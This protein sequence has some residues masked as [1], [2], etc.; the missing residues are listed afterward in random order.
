MGRRRKWAL[1]SIAAAVVL[2]AGVGAAIAATRDTSPKQESQAALNDAAKELG[3]APAKLQTAIENALAKRVDAAVADGRLTTEQGEELKAR[4][5]AGDVPLLAPKLRRGHGHGHFKHFGKLEA[6][7]AYL[8]VGRAE[9]RTALASGK[10]LAE[11]ARDEGKS[12]D[13]LVAALTKAATERL[14]A[15]VAAGRLTKAQRDQIA[16]RLEQRIKSFVDG[17]FERGRWG[18]FGR[19]HGGDF[20]RGNGG[21]PRRDG[22]ATS[23]ATF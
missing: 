16:S 9:L 7:A 18:R 22:S 19:G 14:D 6:A 4:I 21:S 12:V 2:V 3:I 17:T 10:S 11:I 5:K 1:A 23:G 13:G 15:G 20:G 8:G